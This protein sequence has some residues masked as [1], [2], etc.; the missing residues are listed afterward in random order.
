M[1][2]CF[3]LVSSNQQNLHI[4]EESGGQQFRK[5][6]IRGA[7]DWWAGWDLIPGGHVTD[8]SGSDYYLTELGLNT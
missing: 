7:V 8:Y 2:L 6:R 3:F 5:F 1:L 4:S